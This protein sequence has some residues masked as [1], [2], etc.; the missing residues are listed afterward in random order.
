MLSTAAADHRPCLEPAVM[1]LQFVILVIAAI[2]F[3]TAALLFLI[4]GP[5]F[6][7]PRR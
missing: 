6:R 1:V 5:N 4:G 3:P 2:G 7:R